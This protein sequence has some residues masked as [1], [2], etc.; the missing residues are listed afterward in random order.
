M[1]AIVG[2]LDLV[3]WVEIWEMHPRRLM[4]CRGGEA[5]DGILG[6]RILCTWMVDVCILEKSKVSV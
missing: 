3:V 2:A 6:L 5:I 4:L 1:F